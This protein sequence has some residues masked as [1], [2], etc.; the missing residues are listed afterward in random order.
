MFDL[1]A[2][3]NKIRENGKLTRQKRANQTCKTFKFKIDY[4]NLNKKQKEI[5][6]LKKAPKRVLLIF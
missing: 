4:K 2:R 6:L 3:N 1:E 5:W